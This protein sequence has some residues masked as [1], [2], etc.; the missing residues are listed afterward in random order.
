MLGLATFHLLCSAVAYL[1]C[2]R[3]LRL[4]YC[5]ELE[6]N[7]HGKKGWR[8]V[9]LYF[10]DLDL[11]LE[12]LEV[13]H[14][15][16]LTDEMSQLCLEASVGRFVKSHVLSHGNFV[17]QSLRKVR[18]QDSPSPCNG[19]LQKVCCETETLIQPSTE[20]ATWYTLCIRGESFSQ[21]L[22]QREL[23]SS[24]KTEVVMA[25]A[26]NNMFFFF[27]ARAHLYPRLS[28]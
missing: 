8:G 17:S 15:W 18:H 25:V 5:Y 26:G 21:A 16:L 22:S 7:D 19:R 14:K 13:V 20:T 28:V 27:R 6:E 10:V 9:C 11:L 2:E 1:R 24:S 3:G 4:F 23:Y 12:C